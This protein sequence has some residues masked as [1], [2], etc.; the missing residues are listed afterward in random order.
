M[1][2]LPTI[3]PKNFDPKSR[4]WVYQSNRTFTMGEIFEIEPLLE[5][6]VENWKSHGLRV[7]YGQFIVIMA[8]ETA[9]TVGGCSTDS[10][11]HVIKA[12]EQLTGVQ[13]F[14]RT[15]LAFYV[16]DKVQTVPQAQLNYAL[17]NGLLSMDTLYFN[18]LV[19]TKA[20]L[21][22]EWLQPISKSWLAQS[23]QVK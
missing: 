10:S 17:E 6:F 5:N 19:N 3:L 18:N 15:L 23:I 12:I 8:D 13:M 14:N 7:L 11:V 1:V 16:K 20:T 2:D 21:E 4:V 9:T 22:T